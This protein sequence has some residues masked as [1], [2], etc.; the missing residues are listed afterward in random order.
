MFTLDHVEIHKA[1]VLGELASLLDESRDSSCRER[2]LHGDVGGRNNLMP[3]TPRMSKP[4]GPRRPF[5]F[6]A[7]ISKYNEHDIRTC[8]TL[9][10]SGTAKRTIGNRTRTRTP[11][12]EKFP[13]SRHV[14][15][16]TLGED[17]KIHCSV[18]V[19]ALH[20]FQAP[21]Q[22]DDLAVFVSNV[23]ERNCSASSS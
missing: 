21:A 5:K 9:S 15:L 10:R 1:Q 6:S 18:D 23:A 11:R 7:S 19:V 13:G 20:A 12:P 2:D 17:G 3:P 22:P 14:H 16:V 4:P 8:S